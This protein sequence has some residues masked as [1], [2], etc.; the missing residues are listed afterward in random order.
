ML[1]AK[2]ASI[3]EREPIFGYDRPWDDE[4]IDTLTAYFQSLFTQ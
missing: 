1:N 3:F 2:M 4:T